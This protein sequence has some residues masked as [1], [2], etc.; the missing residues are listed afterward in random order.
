[1]LIRNNTTKNIY[2]E[3]LCVLS[4]FDAVCNCDDD[5]GDFW[6]IVHVWRRTRAKQRRPVELRATSRLIYTLKTKLLSASYANVSSA[7]PAVSMLQL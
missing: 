7:A 4:I 5:D 2:I 1:M 6:L 3:Y